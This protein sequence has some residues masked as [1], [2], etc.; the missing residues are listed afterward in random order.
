MRTSD[1][2]RWMEIAIRLARQGEGF[3]EP[4][5]MVGC[6]LVRHGE[7]IGQGFHQKFGGPHAEIEA[8]RSVADPDQL[9]EATAYVTLEPCCHHGKTPPCTE[10]IITSGVRRVVAAMKDPFPR[11]D[12][13]GLA[14]LAAAGIQ[15]DVGVLEPEAEQLMAPYLKL[16]RTGCPWV[17]AKWAM[18]MD[19][20]IAT[21]TG[22]SQWITGEAARAEAHRLRRRVDAIA[23]GM[24]TVIADDPMLTARPAGERRAERI[25]YCRTRLPSLQSRLVQSAHE[26]PLTIVVGPSTSKDELQPL[27]ASGVNVL[28]CES[29]EPTERIS[30][31][32]HWLGRGVANDHRVTNVMVEGGAGLLASFVEAGAVDECHVSIGTKLFGGSTAPGPIA[33]R[34]IEAVRDSLTWRLVACDRFDDDVRLIYRK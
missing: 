17:I 7:C 32:L 15:V 24:G 10:A 2:E 27:Q 8:I 12:G 28:K 1:D 21:R 30:Q 11:V 33:G 13:G 9:R 16:I 4:N 18:T 34:G 31:S 20:R 23:V 25:V 19:G 22:S 3:V 14:R 6:V 5:P 26:V 29:D